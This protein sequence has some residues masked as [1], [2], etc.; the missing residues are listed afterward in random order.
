MDDPIKIIFKY[1]NNNNRIQ[2]HK[3]IFIGDVPANILKILQKI[4]E[5]QFYESLIELSKDEIKT[6]EKFYGDK[7]YL[8]FFNTY[9]INY[10]IEL[11]RKFKKNSDELIRKLGQKWYDDHIKEFTLMDKTILYSYEALIKD[12]II[13]KEQK[14]KKEKII[15]EEELI[16]YTT[17]KKYSMSD[18]SQQNIDQMKLTGNLRES[19]EQA[20]G[21]YEI[22]EIFDKIHRYHHKIIDN[23]N[24][25]GGIDKGQ[26][27]ARQLEGKQDQEDDDE[28]EVEIDEGEYDPDD[29]EE[30]DEEAIDAMNEEEE[31][32]EYYNEEEYMDNLKKMADEND[33]GEIEFDEGL[34]R[35]IILN[36]EDLDIDE[37]EKIYQDTDVVPDKDVSQTTSLIQQAL[38]DDKLFKKLENKAIDFDVSK[39]NLMFDETLRNVFFKNYITTQYIFKDDTI[40]TIR[41]KICASIKNNPKFEQD[42]WIA[43]TRQYLWSEYYFNNKLEKVMLGQKW[44]KKSDILNI[45]IEPNTNIRWYEELRGN[46]K[47]LRD[48]IRRYGSKIKW[49]NDDFNILYDYEGYFTNNELFMIDIYN[50]L[51]KN[52]NPDQEELKNIIDV[53]IRVYYPKIKDDIK[54]II[55]Y[56]NGNIDVESNKVKGIY[57]TIVNDLVLENEVMK[58]VEKSKKEKKFTSLF[59]ETYITQSVIHVGLRTL[60]NTRIN[61]YRIFN[62]FTVDEK[63]PFIQY[64]TIDGQKIFKYNEEHIKVFNKNKDNIDVLTKWFET[65][66]YGI[67]F[68]VRI[69]DKSNEKFMAI[70]LTDNG[71]IEYKTQWKEEDMATINDIQNTYTYVKDLLKKLNDEPNKV[72]FDI[73]I[74]QE[75]K[76]AFMNTI[77][78]FELPGKFTIN[79]NDLSEFSRF[80]F[81]YVALVI[82]PRKRQSKIQKQQDKGKFGT[83]LRY[84][85]VTK[86]E[87]QGRIEQRILYFMKNY[88]YNEQTLSLE[89]SKQ[90]NIP[91]ERALEEIERVKNKYPNIK[92]SR[93]ILK[94]LENI[95]KYKPPGINIDIQGKQ[96]DKYKVRISGARNKD[97]LDRIV[98]FYGTLIYLYVETYLLKKPERQVL[99]EKLKKLNN[100]AKRRNKVD[101]VVKYDDDEK[102]V[103]QMTKL[104]KKRIGFKPEKGQSQW[105]RA[106]QNSGT[107][108]K[109]RPQQ[110]TSVEELNKLGFKLNKSTGVYEKKT[111]LKGKKKKEVII[112]AV[113]LDNIDEEGNTTGSIFYSCNPEENAEHM[114]IGFLLRSN[115][116]YGQPMPCCFKKDQ[117]TAKNK[118]KR[119]Y[120]LKSIGKIEKFEKLSAKI[121]GDKLYILQDT[122]K[123]QDGRIGFLPTY[124]DIMFNQMLNKT[125]KIKHHYLLSSDSGY[126]FKHGVKQETQPFLTALSTALDISIDDII[127]KV[128]EKL[129]KDKSELLFTALNNGDIKTIFSTIDKY[130]EYLKTNLNISFESIN[131][132]LSIP[133]TLKS[134]GINII[135]F[136]K[137]VITI[138]REL[139]KEKIRDDFI[140]MC[141][142]VEEIEN[143]K[144][145]QRDS[146]ILIKE[147]RYF[148]PIVLIQKKEK[149]NKNFDIIK[150]FNYNGNKK[151]NIINHIYDFYEKSCKEEIIG[152]ETIKLNAKEMY[153][154]LLD[155]Q[156]KNPNS[157]NVKEFMPKSQKIDARNKCKYFILNNSLIIP[158]Q[159]SGSIY[160]MSILKNIDNK[161]LSFNE[162]YDKLKELYN[163]S[164][165]IPVKPIGVY[166]DQRLKDKFVING[167]MTE[168]KEFVPII[169]QTIEE[170]TIKKLNLTTE[171]KQLFD[172]VDSAILKGKDNFIID[173]RIINTTENA[174]K[175]EAYNLFR[176][177]LSEYINKDINLNIKKRIMKIIDDKNLNKKE[178]RDKIKFLLFKIIDKN[179]RILYSESLE[180]NKDS[181]EISQ[182]GGTSNKLI[183]VINKLPDLTG[184][185]VNNNREICWS[186]SNKESCSLDKHCH[187]SYDD[188]NLA[189]TR[190]MIIQ[191]VNKVSEEFVSNDHRMLEILQED[192]YFVLDIADYSKFEEREGQK[193]LKSNNANINKTL[194]E[195]FGKENIPLIGKRRQGKSNIE[196]IYEMKLL[197][198]LNNMGEY[199]TQSIMNN[200]ITLFRAFANGYTWMKNMFYDIDN[201]N[202][203]YYSNLQTDMAEYFRS[204][205]IDWITEKKNY[206]YIS[207]DLEKFLDI[208][209]KNAIKEFIN[210]I[211]KDITT[212]T[213]GIVEYYILNKIYDIPIIIYDKYNVILY[214]ID[215]GV[216]YDKDDSANKINDS[217]YNQYKDSSNLKK[218]INIKFTEISISNKPMSIEVIYYK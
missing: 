134:K 98:N 86:Y 118:E 33:D 51:G 169:P 139:E 138:K 216:I 195:L 8:K 21:N 194:N 193:I 120:F 186:F 96:R 2:Y 180:K 117:L 173:E 99:K 12:E 203:G 132:I 146:I 167:I 124:L 68:K 205:V 187:W 207:K 4:Q 88:E 106:C 25:T 104:D 32:E 26:A 154:L 48:N 147:N 196:D 74:N 164:N 214:I 125:R 91:L 121:T 122:N 55:E 143:L 105:T 84:K 190:E 24:L 90:F 28:I 161:L 116:P 115:N 71:R 158:V 44:I 102:N 75:F 155:L 40:K 41:N 204:N 5:K 168:L 87:N 94:K 176:L 61:L 200:N 152:K 73:P 166:F 19:K 171:Y 201:R 9:H 179:L 52:Y 202:L 165:G 93:K 81:P 53:Y 183:H 36:D 149:E 38:K 15:E 159:P 140:V 108:K 145:P 181:E 16:D 218:Y 23:K 69:K 67:S 127:N 185:E 3:Y 206:K 114:Y 57:E 54:N 128:I 141:Q 178:K 13:R 188:C 22:D 212:N 17:V 47:I 78:G 79:H 14:K 142:N 213:N 191:F 30:L 37:L 112:R 197:N 64:Q 76:Y 119:D 82:E 20:G 49:E 103:K 63:Y 45:D 110:Y 174:Y 184:Y 133:G 95:P 111:T 131:H 18:L 137:E 210:K 182:E 72:T 217:K 113:E 123:I 157:K 65:A 11:I 148:Y 215:D 85:R 177:H 153:K 92:K 130:I 156:E 126:F 162:T 58:E 129:E 150:T 27:L 107:D 35:D 43:P 175:N 1:K 77:Q 189:L 198:P 59:K 101:E 170:S 50:D 135:V 80:F 60:N 29:I 70:N 97:Q 208:N 42:A 136:K 144:D 172:K 163:I 66:P 6:L 199:Y 62:E 160:D 39:D 89:I 7:W 109:R 151:D 211:T 34:D 46:L 10:S 31:D 83:Y 192:G 209:K 56:L 100:I